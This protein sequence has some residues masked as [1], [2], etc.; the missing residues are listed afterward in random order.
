[1]LPRVL[2]PVIPEVVE[3][4]VEVPV[5]FNLKMFTWGVDSVQRDVAKDYSF[6]MKFKVKK[7]EEDKFEQ[8][9]QSLMKKDET[10]VHNTGIEGPRTSEEIHKELVKG[11]PARVIQQKESLE[12]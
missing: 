7:G 8:Y 2:Q 4:F 6:E 9:W 5:T 11:T 1:M 10:Q 12:S 3:E